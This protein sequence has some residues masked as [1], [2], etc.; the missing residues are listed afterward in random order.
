MPDI[1][2]ERCVIAAGYLAEVVDVPG[3]EQHTE[4]WGECPYEAGL[5]AIQR[6]IERKEPA[7]ADEREVL[8]TGDNADNQVVHSLRVP[9]LHADQL[10]GM[11]PVGRDTGGIC[12]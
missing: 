3:Y 1:I 5:V 11:R 7:N 9:E 8:A 4:A 12:D 6:A 10:V 2:I